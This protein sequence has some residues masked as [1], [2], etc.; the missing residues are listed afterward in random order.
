MISERFRGIPV[1]YTYNPEDTYLIL[2]AL[3]ALVYELPRTF[4]RY[5]LLKDINTRLLDFDKCEE[6]L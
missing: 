2:R 3:G 4:E 6:K 1:E 5:D